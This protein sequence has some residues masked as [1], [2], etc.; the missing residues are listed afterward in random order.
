MSD[1][2]IGS[3][4]QQP[5]RLS[6]AIGVAIILALTLL[7]VAGVGAVLFDLEPDEGGPPEVA[8][9]VE[10]ADPPV[11]IHNGG[12][13]V[14][15]ERVLLGGTLGTGENLCTYFDGPVISDG[16]SAELEGI[17]PRNGTIVLK[18]EYTET[19]QIIEF[20]EPIELVYD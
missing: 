19:G 2:G 7:L 15:C 8:W 6:T 4:S 12:D 11:L 5:N 3:A 18:W 20:T 9:E 17:T 13:D 1:D 10:A 16:D 14:D